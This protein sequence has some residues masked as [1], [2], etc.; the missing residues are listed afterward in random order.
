MGRQLVLVG[1]GGA[2]LCAGGNVLMA[3]SSLAQI[4]QE[5]ESADR[6][7]GLV[8]AFDIPAMSLADA[9]RRFSTITNRS[10]LFSQDVIGDVRTNG[11]IGEFSVETGLDRLLSGTGLSAQ[12]TSYDVILVTGGRQPIEKK[13]DQVRHQNR[14]KLLGSVATLSALFSSSVAEAQDVSTANDGLVLEE[15]VV[16]GIRGSLRSARDTKRNASGVVDSIAAEDFGKFPDANLAE[17]LQRITGVSIDRSGGEGQFITVRGFGPEFNT[18]LVNGRQ[19]ASEDLSRAFSFDTIAAELVNGITVHKSSTATLQSGGIGSTVNIKTA[20]PF[21]VNGF[22]FVGNVKANYEENSEE[23]SPQASGLISNTFADGKLGILL[24]ASYQK[25]ETRLDALASDGWLENVGIPQAEINGGAGF[26]G[27]IFSP[28]NLDT[29]V[30]FEDRERIGGSLVLQYAPTENLQFTVDGLYSSFDVKSDSNSLGHWFTAPNAENVQLDANGTVIDLFQEVGLSTD[31]NAKTFDR[32]TDTYLIGVEADWQ[33]SDSI[34]VKVDGNFSKAERAANNGGAEL[35][36]IIGF[37]NRVRFQSDDKRLPFLSEFDTAN[38][39]IFSGQQELDGVANLPGVTPDGV[40]NFLDPANGD[41]HVQIRGGWE[42]DDKVRQ[43][44]SD[45]EWDEGASQGLTK[46]R[47]G[48]YYSKQTK[49]LTRWDNTFGPHCTFCGFPDDPEIPA[50]SQTVFDLGDG[51]LGGIKGSERLFTQILVHDPE[52]LIA[53]LENESGVSFDAVRRGN[54]FAVAEETFSG[55]LE[56]EFAGEFMG[57]PIDVVAGVRAEATDVGVSGTDEPIT[58]LSILDRTELLAERAAVIPIQESSS[59]DA[60]LPNLAVRYE[61]RDN[62]ITRFAASQTLTRPTLEA[63]SPVFN[64]TTTRQGGD[65]TATSGNPNLLPFKSDNL[66]LSVEY[67]F[68]QSNYISFGLFRK[69]VS[70]FIVNAQMDETVETA[71]GALLTDPSTGA[72]VFA[73]DP[74]DGLAVFR[75]TRPING[76]NA[77]IR[78]LEAAIQYSFGESGFGVLLNGTIVTGSVDFDPSDVSQIFALTGLSDSA[79]VVGFYDKGP[80]EFRIAY[81]WRDSFLQSLT[82]TNGDGVTFVRSFAQVDISGG[83]QVTDYLRVFFEGTNITN[84]KLFKHGRF[85]NQFLLAE[86][87]G[88]R[89]ALGV[90]MNF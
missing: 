69:D 72:D 47:A 16:S 18:V 70:N 4:A 63:M 43:L 66:D 8:F 49:K 71:S 59:Y 55:Y 40:S 73:P 48:L 34:R 77:V 30:T 80:F 39:N 68:G 24:A 85:D 23:A 84:E 87:S 32:L 61:V 56:M 3:R 65:F 41:P 79:N 9:L 26:D 36:S 11:L 42:V 35:N 19:I 17:S 58:R 67:Y 6:P 12:V 38:P 13:E 76:E 31:F 20:R 57:R 54:S 7:S 27:N 29:R 86:E 5:K 46:L 44:K 15:I 51:F 75:V 90:R 2:M 52:A 89:Y 81:N 1:L 33:V 64:V 60:L 53:F 62:L 83:V 50:G 28:R 21:D 82:Q 25:R 22:K 14:A 88:P 10:L 45:F 37:A 78:G 74:E